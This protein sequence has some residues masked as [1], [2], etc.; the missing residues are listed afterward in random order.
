MNVGNCKAKP[1]HCRM[2]NTKAENQKRF[3]SER[4]RERRK[5]WENADRKAASLQH[6]A[7]LA[8]G[9]IG[10]RSLEFQNDFDIPEIGLILGKNGAN[11]APAKDMSII[12][13]DVDEFGDI[14][15]E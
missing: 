2:E 12:E 10:G 8:T 15:T 3:S 7:A 6:F 9:I 14:E 1:G 13:I 4:E 11:D 5:R